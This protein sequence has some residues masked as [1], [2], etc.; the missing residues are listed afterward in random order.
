[1]RAL[2]VVIREDGRRTEHALPATGLTIGT[3]RDATIA[4]TG[5]SGVGPLNVE[6]VPLAKGCEV[7]APNESAAVL[8]QGEVLHHAVV[9]WGSELSLG[10]IR[11]KLE[12]RALSTARLA[13]GTA[14]VVALAFAAASR[15]TGGAEPMLGAAQAGASVDALFGSAPTCRRGHA[16][17]AGHRARLAEEAALAKMQ[18]YPFAAQDGRDAVALLREAA[19]CHVEEGGAAEAARTERLAERWQAR[20]WED[21]QA[22]RLRLAMALENK[23][24]ADALAEVRVLLALWPRADDELGRELRQRESELVKR[25]EAE[26]KR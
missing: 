20:I 18:R 26:K 24:P 11:V 12:R 25:I 5:P 15:Y 6:L 22:A 23:Q 8:Y 4:I 21:Y 16:E 13:T 7:R 1:M 3:E 14:I 10:S 9:P 2:L 19:R 17:S